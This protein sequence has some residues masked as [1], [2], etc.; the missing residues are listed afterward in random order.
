MRFGFH[1]PLDLLGRDGGGRLGLQR[2]LL[3]IGQANFVR[4]V[5]ELSV[6][7]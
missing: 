3:D 6:G 5:G 7:V 4:D 1:G 2:Q